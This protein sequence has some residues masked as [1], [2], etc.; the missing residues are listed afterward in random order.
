MTLKIGEVKTV[1]A[2]LH[3]LK[4]GWQWLYSTFSAIK[5]APAPERLYNYLA[6]SSATDTTKP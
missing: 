5:L 1:P 2:F 3:S 6:D 4:A